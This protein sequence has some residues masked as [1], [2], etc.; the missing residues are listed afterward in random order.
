MYGRGVEGLG[1]WT[2]FV[3]SIGESIKNGRGCR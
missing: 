2:G 3:E 1:Y